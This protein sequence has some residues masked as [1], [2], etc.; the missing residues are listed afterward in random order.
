MNNE[1]YLRDNCYPQKFIEKCKKKSKKNQ[2]GAT[3]INKKS[4]FGNIN[5]KVDDVTITINKR[6]NT[7]LTRTYRVVKLLI[8]Y[9]T[10]Y[11]KTHSKVQKR[12]RRT[13]RNKLNSCYSAH[14]FVLV[15]FKIVKITVYTIFID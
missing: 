13:E 2:A 10:I 11:S 8:L 6:L 15:L 1:N 5:F 12:L 7:E 3:S 9:K 14:I 4:T